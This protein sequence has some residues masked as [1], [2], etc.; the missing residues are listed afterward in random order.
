MK[1]INGTAIYTGGGCYSIIG[2]ID[3]GLWF[4]GCNDWCAIYDMDTRTKNEDGDFACF[5]YEWCEEHER[6][7][8]FSYKE[9]IAMFKDFC[10]RLDNN[11]EGI[12]NGYEEF[13]NY[14]AG[15]VTDMIDFDYFEGGVNMT[16]REWIDGEKEYVR[17]KDVISNLESL[18]EHGK[19]TYGKSLDEEYDGWYSGVSKDPRIQNVLYCEKAIELLNTLI[20][21]IE[22]FEDED[23]DEVFNALGV[24]R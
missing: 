11:E 4:N 7:L 3:N 15:E 5:Y 12:T 21:H 16:V 23:A 9:V 8:E 2:K 14:I 10:M 24:M 22:N 17:V 1:I 13:S 18:I 6:T 19:E 20:K